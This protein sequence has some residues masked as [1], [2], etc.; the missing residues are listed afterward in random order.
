MSHRAFALVEM[1]AVVVV[2]AA[3]A[4]LL[5]PLG[6]RSRNA[7]GL[8]QSVHNVATLMRATLM[9]HAGEGGRAPLRGARYF[10]S[11]LTGWD[12]WHFGGK[13]CDI[14][15]QSQSQG[16]FDESAFAR[17]LNRYLPIAR[18]PKPSNF[19]ST[20]TS[21]HPGTPTPAQRLSLQI[22]VFRSPGDVATRQRQWPN[23]TPTVTGYND[24]GTSYLLNMKWWGHSSI[25]GGTF[26][27]Q[28]NSGANRVGLALGG[29]TPNYV[30][31]HDQIADLAANGWQ[32]PGEFGEIN[33]SVLGF[34]DGR[35]RYMTVVPGAFSGPGYTF[36]P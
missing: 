7:S 3:V 23:P 25:G 18:I 14:Y 13:N 11:Q 26:T 21:F 5:L 19:V 27:Q 35:V 6:A 20:P 2:V 10:N 24:V 15:W 34:A 8:D 16:T 36:I 9:Y 12:T 31:I 33:K 30:F 1:V 17:P 32:I 22:D 4:V 29:A 28:F